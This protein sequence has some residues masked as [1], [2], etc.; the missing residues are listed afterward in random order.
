VLTHPRHLAS[1]DPVH[2]TGVHQRA[3]DKGGGME[4][5][6]LSPEPGTVPRKLR[7]RRN[8]AFVTAG[9]IAASSLISA[10]WLNDSPSDAASTSTPS[11]AFQSSLD[12]LVTD[13]GFPGVLAAVT[14]P[15][16]S[17]TDYVA[18]VSELGDD[19][20]PPEDGLVRIAS[21]T[22]MYTSVVLL[23]LAEEGLVALDEPIETY[24]PGLV[25]GDGIDG[26]RITVRQ[27]LQHTSG[28]PNYTAAIAGDLFAIRDT[29]LQPRD[30][31]DLALAMPA[32]FEPASSYEYSNTNYV[33]AGLLIEKVTQRPLGEQIT[34][35]IIDPL[36]LEETYF[37]GVGDRTIDGPHPSGY[38]TNAD[39]E[40]ENITT[41]DPSWAWAAG[42]L[43]ASPSDVNRFMQ[44]LAGGELLGTD[45]AGNDLLTQMQTTIPAA[46]LWEGA[47][48]G[49]GL[50]SYPLSCGGVAWGHGGDV[51][52]FE[53]RNAV[54][55]SGRA[56]TIAV[57][58]LPSALSSDED[59][60]LS[61]MKNIEGLVDD[62]LCA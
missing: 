28:L 20:P 37:P 38:H 22:K 61:T 48:Y 62:A 60:V 18:G 54:N 2:P 14:E 55:E 24:L 39:G 4:N 52:G 51:S 47:E 44:A 13:D 10:V 46:E 17:V 34:D 7:R 45:P 19:A 21:N 3:G 40:L 41:T 32:S 9:V 59:E 16:G 50:I 26:S 31:L 29:Y 6:P 35:R 58:A 56:V 30:L 53:T 27:L 15:D 33:V 49:L 23:Q 5:F 36:G 43:I 8:I 42:Q 25:H 1:L 57:T 12:D 11:S